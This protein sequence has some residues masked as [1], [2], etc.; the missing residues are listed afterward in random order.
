MELEA[1]EKKQWDRDVMLE[2]ITSV[3]DDSTGVKIY[4]IEFG[5]VHITRATILSTGC[6]LANIDKINADGTV[7]LRLEELGTIAILVDSEDRVVDK[8][9]ANKSPKTGE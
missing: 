7:T 9:S 6:Q 2:S 5:Q 4:G 1:W 3:Y 8:E